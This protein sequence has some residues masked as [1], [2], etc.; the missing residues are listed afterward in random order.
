VRKNNGFSE[1]NKDYR[2]CFK[3]KSREMNICF[4]VRELYF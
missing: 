1:N 4:L 3:R 2:G